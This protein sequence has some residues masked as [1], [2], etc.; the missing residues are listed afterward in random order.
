LSQRLADFVAGRAWLARERADEVV[1]EASEKAAVTIASLG[2]D[3]RPLIHPNA[4]R[5]K[6]VN[7]VD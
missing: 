2:E 4:T 6:R 3:A 5:D 7:A 1:R